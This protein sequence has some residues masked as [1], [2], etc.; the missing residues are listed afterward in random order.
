MRLSR[1]FRVI[2]L[3]TWGLVAMP[4]LAQEAP[5]ALVKRVTDEVLT[6]IKSDKDLQAGN[7]RKVAGAASSAVRAKACQR[8]SM[9]RWAMRSRSGSRVPVISSWRPLGTIRCRLIRVLPP[10]VDALPAKTAG[11]GGPGWGN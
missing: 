4:A 11:R 1:M 5:D 9:R 2:M 8:R 6:I 10:W 3:A 7:S